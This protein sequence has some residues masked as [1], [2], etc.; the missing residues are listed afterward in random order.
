MKFDL[1]AML[2][3][4]VVILVVVMIASRVAPI[5]RIVFGA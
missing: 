5:R 2:I 4:V 3:D 1:K